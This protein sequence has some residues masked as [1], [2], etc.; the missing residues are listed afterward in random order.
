MDG[1]MR[2]LHTVAD[3]LASYAVC[4]SHLITQMLR[5]KSQRYANLFYFSFKTS[6][7]KDFYYV[8]SYSVCFFLD[9]FLKST[10]PSSL[11]KPVDCLS[12]LFDKSI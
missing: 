4:T 3:H 10:I 7:L 9:V 12:N 11:Y 6:V 8:F 2:C 1:L 5:P